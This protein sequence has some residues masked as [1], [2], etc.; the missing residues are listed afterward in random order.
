MAATWPQETVTLIRGLPEGAARDNSVRFV[1][2][3]SDVHRGR[4]LLE[5][6]LDAIKAGLFEADGTTTV[7]HTTRVVATHEPVWAVEL[8]EALMAR[9]LTRPEETLVDSAFQAS[10]PWSAR[11]GFGGEEAIATAARKASDDFVDRL[12]P[13]AVELMRRHARG[14]GGRGGPAFDE[15]WGVRHYGLPESLLDDLFAGLEVSLGLMA[16]AQPDRAELVFERLRG[17]NL[18]SGWILLARGYAGNP[19]RFADQAADWLSSAPGS[20]D[21][22]FAGANHWVTRDL[23]ASISPCCSQESFDRLVDSLLYFTPDRERRFSA[24]KRRGW[25]ELCLLNGLSP[26]RRPERAERRLAE[27]RRKFLRDDVSPPQV[28]EGGL[29]PP[30]IAQDRASRMTDAQWI[31]A[32]A[33]HG[34]SDGWVGDASQQAQI[35]EDLTKHDPSRFARL[36]LRLPTGTSIAYVC[37]I[38]RGISG[39]GLD[40]GLLL[41]VV[42]RAREP[43]TSEVNQWVA[44]LAESEAAGQV[45]QELLNTISDIAINDPDPEDDAWWTQQNEDPE[46]AGVN[47]TRGAAAYAIATLLRQNPTRLVRLKAAMAALVTDRTIQVRAMATRA[48]LP[49]L[50]IEPDAAFE[51][52]HACVD[53]EDDRLLAARSVE[54]FL[55]RAVRARYP[56]VADVLARMITSQTVYVRR[57]GARQLAFASTLY[58]DLDSQIDQ[59]LVSDDEHART[60][61]VEAFASLASGDRADRCFTVLSAAFNDPSAAVREAAT[62][63]VRGPDHQPLDARLHALIARFL[64]SSSFRDHA[65]SLLVSLD[66]STRPLPHWALDVCERYIEVAGSAMGNLAKRAASDGHHLVRIVIRMLTQHT[67]PDIRRRCLDLIDHLLVLG[68]HDIDEALISIE[69]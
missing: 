12:L 51:L 57:A 14:H 3:L 34:D 8:L 13:L 17:E 41:D 35:L 1:L 19:A 25:G 11:R 56:E 23:I 66:Q 67:N 15:I 65:G 31:G 49:V 18:E 54:I 7:W 27:L 37:G 38:L 63:C 4:A 39:M 21:L 48:I 60:G 24:L 10:G 6:M 2:Q 32:I 69:R 62:H 36:L 52:F 45:P 43:R 58:P 47:C 29:I 33:K 9:M 50:D 28:L 42:R 53:V 68:A 5:L 59:L 40:Q 46:S 26:A 22:G 61:V 16:Q 30:P 64:A 20:L 55:N 44:W